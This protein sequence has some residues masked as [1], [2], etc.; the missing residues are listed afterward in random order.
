MSNTFYPQ[1]DK[2][3][4]WVNIVIED[5]LQHYVNAMQ[6]DWDKLSVYHVCF[7]FMLKF[8]KVIPKFLH[9]RG[10]LYYMSLAK[11]KGKDSNAE[12]LAHIAN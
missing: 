3:V 8:C 4:E 5:M 12:V 9:D 10:F 6:D 1:T 7:I 2:H 11:F